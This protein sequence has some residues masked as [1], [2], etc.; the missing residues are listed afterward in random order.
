M[1]KG[2]TG[3][4]AAAFPTAIFLSELLVADPTFTEFEVARCW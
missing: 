3:P 4:N 1:S 2:D